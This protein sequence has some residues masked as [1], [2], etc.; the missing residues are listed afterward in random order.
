VTRSGDVGAAT[1]SAEG[2]DRRSE[3]ALWDAAEHDPSPGWEASPLSNLDGARDGH[4]QREGE[5]VRS[6][7]LFFLL[8]F[9]FSWLVWLPV[10]ALDGEISLLGNL[11]VGLAAAGPSVAGVVCIARD[12]G[13]RGVGDCSARCS[14][15][16]WPPSGTCCRSGADG[17]GPPSGGCP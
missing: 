5:S 4:D 10:A 14:S 6:E 13:R 12:D 3:R 16:T 11:A 1:E 7:P 17:S 15:G 8:V 9:A 2:A